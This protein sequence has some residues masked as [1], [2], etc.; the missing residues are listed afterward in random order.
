[1]RDDDRSAIARARTSNTAFEDGFVTPLT[2]VRGALEILRDYPEPA[3]RDRQQFVLSALAAYQR[4]EQP[5]EALGTTV[6]A[7]RLPDSR[8]PDSQTQSNSPSLANSTSNNGAS[9]GA[10]AGTPPPDRSR[11]KPFDDIGVIEVDFSERAF[12]SSRM[13]HLFYDALEEFV[14]ASEQRWFLLVNYRNRSVWPTAWV[15]LH[16]GARR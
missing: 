8:L 13:I 12:R 14:S 10:C 4:I 11:I 7:A 16:T 9:G 5:V 2:A 3:T 6:Y 1:M 15:A